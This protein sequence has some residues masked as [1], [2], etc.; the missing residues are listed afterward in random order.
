MKVTILKY[1][2]DEDWMLVKKAA[3][4]TISKDTDILPSLEWKQKMLKAV[5]SPVRLLNYTVLLSDIPSWVSVHLVRHIHAQPFV[6]TQRNDRCKREEGYDRRKAP[7]DTPVDMIWSFNAEELITICHK[8]MCMLASP[9]TRKVVQDV[10]KAIMDI[11]PEW[12]GTDLLVPLCTYRGGICTE[13]KPCSYYERHGHG[14]VAK[15]LEPGLEMLLCYLNRKAD[16][17]ELTRRDCMRL[18]DFGCNVGLE[19][20]RAASSEED[21]RPSAAVGVN[22][23]GSINMDS[24]Y[25]R[26]V[27]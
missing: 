9:E 15:G 14:Y 4:V 20:A 11:C 6:S 16:R 13:F 22:P 23:D 10:A 2:S 27:R 24:D 7:Q 3:F 21:D 5:H 1:P 12:K 25:A 26:Y 18:E 17:K 8:R 19:I